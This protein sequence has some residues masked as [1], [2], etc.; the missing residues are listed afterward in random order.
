MHKS[1]CKT[2]PRGR[3][4]SWYYNRVY[5]SCP[6]YHLF[7]N[8]LVH[9]IY[10]RMSGQFSIFIYSVFKYLNSYCLLTV[11]WWHNVCWA[12]FLN[13]MF[14]LIGMVGL[15]R[16]EEVWAFHS[17]KSSLVKH[18]EPLFFF[19]S[20][21]TTSP[22]A[23]MKLVVFFRSSKPPYNFCWS[24][25]ADGHCAIRSGWCLLHLWRTCT[26]VWSSCWEPLKF[27]VFLKSFDMT[28]YRSLV[29]ASLLFVCT[30]FIYMD[31]YEDKGRWQAMFP[32]T[33][34]YLTL[35]TTCIICLHL[36]HKR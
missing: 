28:Q 32:K 11:D 2:V 29:K 12:A 6:T 27:G 13:Y 24:G 23:V 34:I 36:V 14:F 17:D 31:F 15:S 3:R 33:Q 25:V 18:W 10:S 35:F 21:D 19:I 30:Y 7:C 4:L 9:V 8:A 5:I 1:F 22:A 20:F 16:W 26:V